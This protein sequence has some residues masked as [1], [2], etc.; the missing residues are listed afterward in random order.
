MSVTGEVTA[1]IHGFSEPGATPMPWQTALEQVS[2][3]DT[4][5]I[6]TVRPDGRPDVTPLIAVWHDDA[7]WFTTGPG[8]RKARNLSDNPRS[9]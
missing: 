2:A 3:A 1:E 6:S 9:S 5:W 8:E 7:I 4:F